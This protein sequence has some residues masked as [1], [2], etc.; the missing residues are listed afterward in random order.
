MCFKKPKAP[1][2][3]AEDKA[4]E[5]ELEEELAARRRELQHDR[6]EDKKEQTELAIARAAGMFG[7]RSLIAGPKGGSGF[8]R[9]FRSVTPVARGGGGGNAITLPGVGGG[10][11]SLIT[12]PSG[13]GG[14][15]G[16]GSVHVARR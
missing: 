9:G 1:E 4:R 8:G 2:P 7:F 15:G 16:G 11:G 13:G 14:G 10:G 3:T 12:G 5:K 6:A